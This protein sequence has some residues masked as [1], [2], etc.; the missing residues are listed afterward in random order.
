VVGSGV[1][2]EEWHGE[3][4]ELLSAIGWRVGGV[5]HEP[6]PAHSPTLVV[7]EHLAGTARVSRLTGMDLA[8]ATTARAAIR[9][10]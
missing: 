6:P 3:V 1:P 4:S 2:A 7:L 5:D 9:Q 8:V 10:R